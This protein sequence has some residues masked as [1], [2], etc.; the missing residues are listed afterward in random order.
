MIL[1]ARNVSYFYQS[2]R[3]KLILD[4]VSY[5]FECGRLYAILG[6]SGA[7]KT[8]LLSLLAG[9][10]TPVQGEIRYDGIPVTPKDLASP[11]WGSWSS[12]PGP[13]ETAGS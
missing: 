12:G 9:L 13:S 2:Q 11:V 6:P 1:E 4:N 3:D 8:T 10:D 7:G 5:G